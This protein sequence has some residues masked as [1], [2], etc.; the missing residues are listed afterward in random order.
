MATYYQSTFGSGQ[1]GSQYGGQYMYPQPKKPP[2][3]VDPIVSDPNDP[4]LGT[5]EPPYST[6]AAP[7]Q[8][9]PPAAGPTRPAFDFSSVNYSNDPILARVRA[10]AEESVG[11]ANAD[12]RA[13]RVRLAIGLGD[14][15]LVD[16][17][18][19]GGDVRKQAQENS[20]GTFQE[21]AR[22]LSRRNVDVNS[23]LSDKANLFYSTTRGRQLGLSG[24]QFL[25]D[26]NTATQTV[27]E[28]LAQ[29]SQQVLAA[30]M[31]AQA[32]TIAAE[33]DAYSRAL[34]QALYA[35]GAA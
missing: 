10:L 14:P 21:L 7:P 4:G 30:K 17:L 12:A 19:L 34:Q 35:A 27:Q 20:F 24:E 5:L 1:P 22:Q 6:P 28:R 11:Q 33:Q 13:N 25:R 15:D 26:R 18:K 31:A 29:I 8:E 9:T 32:Q 16:K 23:Q 3:Y 2:Y